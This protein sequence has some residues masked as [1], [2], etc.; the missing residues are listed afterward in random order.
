ADMCLFDQTGEVVAT[1]E[2]LHLKRATRD[3]LR[4]AARSVVSDW[5]YEVTWRQQ[6][7]STMPADG[8]IAEGNWLVLSDGDAAAGAHVARELA[9]RGARVI[10]AEPGTQYET[11]GDRHVR[12]NP[13]ATED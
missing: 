2:G 10:V 9:R 13:I 3:A 12:L 11:I 5:L 7:A 8:S 4:R 6:S 1:V